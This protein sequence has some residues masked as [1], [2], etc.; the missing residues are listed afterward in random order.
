V[1]DLL[2]SAHTKERLA[3][4]YP[5]THLKCVL[6]VAVALA[7]AACTGGA[8]LDMPTGPVDHGCHHGEGKDLGGDGS[9]CS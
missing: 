4:S 7:V 2:C 8:G 9:G 6:V 1:L 3:K 5:P